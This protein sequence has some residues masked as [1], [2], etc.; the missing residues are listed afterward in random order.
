MQYPVLLKKGQ[1]FLVNREKE[2]FINSGMSPKRWEKVF[3]I[4][5]YQSIKHPGSAVTCC[6]DGDYWYVPFECF[7][8]EPIE[9]VIPPRVLDSRIELHT[10]DPED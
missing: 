7:A 9:E 10:P 3:T 8:Y 6:L 4:P 1:S 5:L 2:A